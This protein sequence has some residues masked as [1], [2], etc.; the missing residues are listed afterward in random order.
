MKR[1]GLV[2]M[3]LYLPATTL[4]LYSSLCELIPNLIDGHNFKFCAHDAMLAT[5]VP[6]SKCLLLLYWHLV[7]PFY[8]G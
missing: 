4:G 8:K 2:L 5:L 6:S 1:P 3:L 7:C